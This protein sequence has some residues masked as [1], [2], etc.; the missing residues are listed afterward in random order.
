MNGS[1]QSCLSPANTGGNALPRTIVT[2]FDRRYWNLSPT[3]P[4]STSGGLSRRRVGGGGSGTISSYNDDDD[5]NNKIKTSNSENGRGSRSS[6]PP[7]AAHHAHAGSAFE[8]GN[9]IAFDP[10]DLQQDASEAARTGGKMP[11]L[12]IM[13]EVLLLGIKD[14]QVP[15]LYSI[16]VNTSLIHVCL[17][18]IS[19]SGTTTSHM[20]CVAAF[21]SS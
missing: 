16:H 12:T 20:P 3:T 1:G 2:H 21:L 7:P 14:K 19:L 8:G 18:V 10:R 15:L 13:E 17:R 11:R 5:N 9:K 4:M 6:S